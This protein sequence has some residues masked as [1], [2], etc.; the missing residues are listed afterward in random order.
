MDFSITKQLVPFLR[1]LADD[2]ESNEV[3]PQQLQQIGDFFMSYKF[4]EQALRD[5]QTDEITPSP[6][7]PQELTKFLFMGWYIY[8]L[9]LRSETLNIE[10]ND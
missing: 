7:S 10:N 4:Q 2:I 5:S 9:L 8:Q 1:K 3:V 6:H